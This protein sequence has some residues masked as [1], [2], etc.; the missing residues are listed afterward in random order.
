[1]KKQHEDAAASEVGRQRM[2]DYLEST[3]EEFE[4]MLADAA[5]L[6]DD[7]RGVLCGPVVQTVQRKPARYRS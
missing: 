7:A 5:L 2:N 4:A 1:M 3:R 6:G